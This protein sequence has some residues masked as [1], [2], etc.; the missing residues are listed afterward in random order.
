M[1]LIR[2]FAFAALL[3]P[4]AAP[5]GAQDVAPIFEQVPA[6]MYETYRGTTSNFNGYF[7]ML[8][9]KYAGSDGYGWAI[10]RE[11]PKVAYRI[12]VLPEGLESLVSVQQARGASFGDFTEDQIDL[13]NSSWGSRHVAVYG[14][15]PALSYVPEGFTV[16]DIRAL[17]YNRTIVYYLKWDQAG[18]FRDALRQR[19]ELDRAHGIDNLVLTTWNGGIGTQAQTV[20]IR[21]SAADQDADRAALAERMEIRQAGD[22]E[23]WQR[24]SRIMNDATWHMERHDQTRQNDLSWTP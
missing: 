24:L 1:K 11:N 16:D 22:W 7:E 18:A 21:V 10:Y 20:M 13:W 19:A 6:V 3:L 14:A 17:P 12:T 9:D 15:A 4:V 5:A 8:V 23:E 2:R